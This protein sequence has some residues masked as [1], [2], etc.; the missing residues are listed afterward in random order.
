MA[1]KFYVQN[2]LVPKIFESMR[3]ASLSRVIHDDCYLDGNVF[4]FWIPIYTIRS[5]LK[6]VV[7]KN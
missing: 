2:I 1:K 7:N 3:C 4:V 5:N 6:L